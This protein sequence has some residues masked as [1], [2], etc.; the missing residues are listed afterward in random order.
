MKRLSIVLALAPRL[1]YAQKPEQSGWQLEKREDKMTDK[2]VVTLTRSAGDTR[3]RISCFE[4]KGA[5]T[6]RVLFIFP[7]S[8]RPDTEL[9]LQTRFDKE[10]AGKALLDIMDNPMLLALIGGADGA[11]NYMLVASD[12]KAILAAVGSRNLSPDDNALANL[13]FI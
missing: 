11:S 7:P 9:I 13:K 10:E 4:G 2:T 12:E 6:T 3:L 5:P 8:P 1:L